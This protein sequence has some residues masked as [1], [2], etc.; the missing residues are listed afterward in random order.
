MSAIADTQHSSTAATTHCHTHRA[1]TGSR[2]G[3]SAR[4][5]RRG[6][7]AAASAPRTSS[8]NGTVMLITLGV[9][10]LTGTRQRA[11]VTHDSPG[12]WAV[13]TG[14]DTRLT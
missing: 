9:A 12:P 5:S 3:Q 14:R 6:A 11:D 8:T 7:V 2:S 13:G 1:S 4:A 10:L